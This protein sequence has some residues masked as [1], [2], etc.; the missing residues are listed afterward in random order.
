MSSLLHF[1]ELEIEE[2]NKYK[3]IESEKAGYDLGIS[4][5]IEWVDLYAKQFREWYIKTYGEIEECLCM[6]SIQKDKLKKKS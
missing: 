6:N 2:I 1:I 4:A 5:E 3:W